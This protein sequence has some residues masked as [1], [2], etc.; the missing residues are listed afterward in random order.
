MSLNIAFCFIHETL[1]ASCTHRS[2]TIPAKMN[3]YDGGLTYLPRCW[4]YNNLFFFIPYRV[5]GI[6]C[7]STVRVL[8][9]LHDAL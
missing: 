2:S 5:D 7:A 4:F 6:V 3:Q 1:K 8:D 9:G